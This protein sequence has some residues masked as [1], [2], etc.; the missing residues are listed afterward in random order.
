MLFKVS[1]PIQTFLQ[2]VKRSI[3]VYKSKFFNQIIDVFFWCNISILVFAYIM[4][5]MGLKNLGFFMLI[6][7]VLS[8]GFWTG[9]NGI[10]AFLFEINGDQSNLRYELT[11]P[12]KQSWIFI[13]Y[14]VINTYQSFIMSFLVLPLGIALIWNQIDFTHFSLLKFYLICLIS[15][16][17][18]AAL[19]LLAS[20]F[21]TD[22]DNL[23]SIFSRILWPL[24]MLGGFNFS[25]YKLYEIN[26][27]I[28]YAT[29]LNPI[30]YIFEGGRACSLDPALSLPF[31][32][33]FAAL[34]FFTII[35]GYLGICKLKKRMDCL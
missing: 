10:A 29:L 3:V 25:W 31:W 11:L 7:N 34:I 24:W 13:K 5:E 2:L 33:C 4:P 26:H 27:T 32:H 20:A 21:T 1:L 14:G 18:T 30:T 9:I 19:F 8:A 35:F 22:L 15:C 16:A 23:D 6:G 17:F 12:I 28:A